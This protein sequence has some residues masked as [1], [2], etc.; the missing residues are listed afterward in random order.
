V[1]PETVAGGQSENRHVAAGTIEGQYREARPGKNA[2][3]RSRRHALETA[4]ERAEA[5]QRSVE[6]DLGGGG[7][8]TL[9]GVGVG[10]Q[11][12]ADSRLRWMICF[13]D[14]SGTP[15]G[16]PRTAGAPEPAVSAP[17]VGPA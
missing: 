11:R 13:V 4:A 2:G 5:F 9:E 16:V 12:D 3:R 1:S 10:R 8:F 14:F 7:L 6:V 17:V 15:T